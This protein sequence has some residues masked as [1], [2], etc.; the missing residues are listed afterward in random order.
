MSKQGKVVA[1]SAYGDGHVRDIPDVLRE[2]GVPNARVLAPGRAEQERLPGRVDFL[3]ALEQA[4]RSLI[5]DPSGGETY[6]AADAVRENWDV[7]YSNAD[8]ATV[9]EVIRKHVDANQLILLDRDSPTLAD[10]DA[11]IDDTWVFQLVEGMADLH[12]IKVDRNGV[13]PTVQLIT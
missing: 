1:S 7:D 12:W 8:A 2:L 9:S 11:S 6:N 5:E 10:A 13:E 4:L 3:T